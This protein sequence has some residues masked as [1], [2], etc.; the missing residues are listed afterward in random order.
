MP[1]RYQSKACVSVLWA[2]PLLRSL[3]RLISDYRVGAKAG[4]SL[5]SRYS[6]LDYRSR[7]FRICILLVFGNTNKQ[8][9][10]FPPV[11]S[12]SSLV[13]SREGGFFSTSTPSAIACVE[14]EP[15]ILSFVPQ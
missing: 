15:R 11:S 3:S 9:S 10:D 7:A 4:L 8:L 13:D 5:A 12:I 2:D 6:G 14:E 1:Q